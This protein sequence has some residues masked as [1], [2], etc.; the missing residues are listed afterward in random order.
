M[1]K[2]YDFELDMSTQNSNSIIIK[3]IPPKSKVLEFGCAYGR[4]TKYLVENLGCDVTIVE[5]DVESGL[6][7]IQ[8]VP[9]N[10]SYIGPVNGDID[11][12]NWFN[13]LYNKEFFDYIIFADVLE[14]LQNQ[15]HALDCAFK[16]LN[17]G[18]SI[19]ISVPNI[20]HNSVII[21]L[22]LDKFEYRDAGLLDKTHIK[23][24]TKSSLKELIQS[25]NMLVTKQFNLINAVGNTEFNNNYD[26]VPK[27]VSD[28]LKR[29]QNGEVYQFV[30][31]L[32]KNDKNTE[33]N[34]PGIQ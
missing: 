29:K 30:W 23:F 31:E 8:L 15:K 13:Q 34:N 32:K 18:G 4:M 21:D 28:F 33:H 11:K 10:H 3:H 16:L 22:M 9:D 20:A 27:P 26:S 12:D 19:W 6:R 1:N 5:K 25:S 14:H 2:M 7:A 24:F 17:A